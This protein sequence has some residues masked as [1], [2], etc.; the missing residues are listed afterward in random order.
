MGD[1]RIARQHHHASEAIPPLAG[2]TERAD[3]RDIPV[4]DITLATP[5][6]G[7]ESLKDTGAFDSKR[8][9]I[10]YNVSFLDGGGES[11]KV[12]GAGGRGNRC[13]FFVKYEDPS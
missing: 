5:L 12:R 10:A 13:S 3:Q 4:L 11:I 6:E 8:Q 1:H 7:V 2:M 9:R